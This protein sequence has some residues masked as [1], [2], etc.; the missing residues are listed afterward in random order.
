MLKDKKKPVILMVIALLSCIL[1]VGAVSAADT[2]SANFTTN[3]TNGFAPLSV[4]FNDT[5]TG[6]PNSWNWDFGSAG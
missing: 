4:Q 2:P 5:S 6:N 3:T 1:A